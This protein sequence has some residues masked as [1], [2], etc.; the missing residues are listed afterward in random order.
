MTFTDHLR[1]HA[2]ALALLALA[3]V[4]P[5]AA[6][7][8]GR[9]GFFYDVDRRTDDSG[10]VSDYSLITTYVALR[11][12]AADADGFEYALDARSSTYPS[13]Q[14]QNSQVSIYDAY[15]GRTMAD[16]K[17]NFRL[18]QMWLNDMGALGAV[19]GANLEYRH[20][21]E[22]GGRWRAGLFAGL[23]PTPFDAGYVKG[24]TKGGLYAAYEGH[25]GEKHVLGLIALRNNGLAER[26]VLSTTNYLPI[27]DKVYIYQ[28]AE[29]DLHGP[30]G[31]GP[32]GLN[33]F[34]VTARVIPVQALEVQIN[35]NHGRSVDT[36]TITDE[37]RHGQPV[38]PRLLDGYLFDSIGGRI[39]VSLS[40]SVRI[41]AG[42]SQDRTNRNEPA[43]PRS[44]A[45]VSLYN[46][47][48]SGF[49]LTASASRMERAM[50]PY[51]SIYAS[52]GRSITSRIY[53]SADYTSS[54][55]VLQMLSNGGVMIQTRPASRR[56]S[57]TSTA[58]IGRH[59]SLFLTLERFVEDTAY[60]NRLT[61]GLSFRF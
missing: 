46:I 50:G 42:S 23:E 30:G 12:P 55:S 53:I 28:V 19:G 15:V 26:T 21:T 24:V 35:Y 7:S 60:T 38:D 40:R 22:T 54:L 51:T 44:T 57:L 49:D 3:A 10:L 37:M 47:L 5:L 45:G 52:I 48:G 56:F 29:Y 11:P 9:V 1:R 32:G 18:G 13:S 33:Y 36:R 6:Q 41:Y 39:T 2:L 58:N 59:F 17:L 34:F 43:Y 8:I 20:P 31:E 61:T 25:G 16:G 4:R 14:D 27:A